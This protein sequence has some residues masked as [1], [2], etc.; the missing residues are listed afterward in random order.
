MEDTDK[1]PYQSIYP[2]L[3]VPDLKEIEKAEAPDSPD[4]F[5]RSLDQD[6]QDLEEFPQDARS[7]S[8]THSED[9]V[10]WL[11]QPLSC[12]WEQQQSLQD[13][14]IYQ[15]L[16][17]QYLQAYKVQAEKDLNTWFS[18]VDTTEPQAGFNFTDSTPEEVLQMLEPLHRQGLLSRESIEAS[19]VL[20]CT[21]QLNESEELLIAQAMIKSRNLHIKAYESIIRGDTTLPEIVLAAD[22]EDSDPTSWIT[23]QT[24]PHPLLLKVQ[25]FLGPTLTLA[26]AYATMWHEQQ[27]WTSPRWRT[28]YNRHP[29][30]YPDLL[31]FLHTLW[32]QHPLK[33]S[34]S[35]HLLCITAFPTDL[36][37]IL[38]PFKIPQS[39]CETIDPQASQEQKALQCA[40][41]QHFLQSLPPPQTTTGGKSCSM[42]KRI[43]YDWARMGVAQSEV[44]VFLHSDWT[45]WGMKFPDIMNK[46]ISLLNNYNIYPV[47]FKSNHMGTGKLFL[48][49]K[50][51]KDAYATMRVLV[52]EAISGHIRLPK[53]VTVDWSHSQMAIFNTFYAGRVPPE[54]VSWPH[55]DMQTK[56]AMAQPLNALGE[57]LLTDCRLNA[58][59]SDHHAQWDQDQEVSDRERQNRL[60]S[61]QA[62]ERQAFER[63]PSGPGNVSLGIHA[64]TQ[65]YGTN[66]SMTGPQPTGHSEEHA[67]FMAHREASLQANREREDSRRSSGFYGETSQQANRERDRWLSEQERSATESRRASAFFGSPQSSTASREPQLYSRVYDDHDGSSAC[68]AC[69]EAY[70]MRGTQSACQ[71]CQQKARHQFSAAYQPGTAPAAR[72]PPSRGLPMHSTA[73]H[74]RDLEAQRHADSFYNERVMAAGGNRDSQ[75]GPGFPHLFVGPANERYCQKCGCKAPSYESCRWANKQ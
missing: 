70:H 16:Q 24:N 13:T 62:H 66:Q 19:Q 47:N 73:N 68:K 36:Q 32:T 14:A 44:E 20:T 8:P 49:L 22:E 59:M 6:Q 3:H 9:S 65:V 64:S 41:Q 71:D 45:A 38:Q 25:D 33:S 4:L 48:I 34:S 5:G 31:T 57:R 75:A 60:A 26:Q 56:P 74:N 28:V 43:N 72:L 52:D 27:N 63:S 54:T 55:V 17:N 29:V 67:A 46:L 30:L 21:D 53:P 69:Q 2:Q 23:D 12:V 35:L 1:K 42:S 50:D 15:T 58:N 11:E 10:A 37:R 61:N 7:L 39:F 18:P 51:L 40:V